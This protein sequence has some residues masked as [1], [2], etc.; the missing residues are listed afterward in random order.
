MILD[1]RLEAS[2][3]FLLLVV[4]WFGSVYL[5]PENIIKF[6]RFQNFIEFVYALQGKYTGFADLLLYGDHNSLVSENNSLA[7]R[8]VLWRRSFETM[9]EHWMFGIGAG[10]TIRL[11]MKPHSTIVQALVELGVVGG[12]LFISFYAVIFYGFIR[13][14]ISGDFPNEIF[15]YI[16]PLLL[17]Y[18]IFD[19]LQGNLCR[20]IPSLILAGIAVSLYGTFLKQDSM[21]PPD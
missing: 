14:L 4:S 16:V 21:P 7:V 17:Y 10:E 12:A 3:H 15:W 18:F 13:K 6:Y 20:N 9:T 8:A 1:Y 5:M 19:Q 11:G 2:L